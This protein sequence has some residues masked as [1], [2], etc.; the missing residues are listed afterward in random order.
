MGLRG[1]PEDRVEKV[2]PYWFGAP[3][4]PFRRRSG[5]PFPTAGCKPSLATSPLL[6]SRAPSGHAGGRRRPHEATSSALPGF[7]P[8]QRMRSSGFGHRELRH[9]ARHLPSSAFRT[10]S[11]VYTPQ[12]RPGLFHPGN[13]HG[14]PP[15]GLRS[16]PGSRDLSRGP[17]LSC[18]SSHPIQPLSETRRPATSELRSPQGVRT[19]TGRNPSAAA[20][21]L[22]LSPLRLSRS[23][24]PAR[25]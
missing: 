19:A 6:T 8:L 22:A 4:Q 1:S 23:P 5:L 16:S 18:R 17:L 10:L 25:S 21:L 12:P 7:L 9:G 24:A 2:A 13:A 3:G 20:A 15:T 11:T 14:V